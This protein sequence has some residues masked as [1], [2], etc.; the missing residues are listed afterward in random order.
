MTTLTQTQLEMTIGALL[1]RSYELHNTADALRSDAALLMKHGSSDA[2][3]L[4]TDAA[5]ID[6]DADAHYTLAHSLHTQTQ[7]IVQ[8][9]Q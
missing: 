6:D 2:H 7:C 4:M 3:R 1:L 5:R 8:L 9:T